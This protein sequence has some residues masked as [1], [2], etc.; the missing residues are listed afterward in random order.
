MRSLALSAMS[1]VLWSCAVAPQDVADPA[2]G[3]P[4]TL[5][6]VTVEANPNSV[7]SC[8]VTW[9]TSEPATSAVEFGAELPY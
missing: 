9:T 8:I 4:S 5:T 7:L 3:A 1:M 6:G 2:V